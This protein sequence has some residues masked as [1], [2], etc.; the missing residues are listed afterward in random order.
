MIWRPGEKALRHSV[1]GTAR[2]LRESRIRRQCRHGL[3]ITPV[4]IVVTMLMGM[5]SASADRIVLAPRGTIQQ[6]GAVLG[7][8]AVQ[9]SHTQN[10]LGF[11][12]LGIPGNDLG[13]ELEVERDDLWRT[14]RETFSL[15]YLVIPEGLTN[16]IGPAISV[17][18]RDIL[19]RGREGR[20]FFLAGTKSFPLSRNQ[21]RLVRDLKL[22]GG[23]GT[24][25]L[26]GPFVG[27]EARL[28]MGFRI[29]AEYAAR[30]PDFELALPAGKHVTLRAYTL[31][32]SA[33]YGASLGWRL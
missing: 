14:T 13:L 2:I 31:D 28:T 1:D 16:N 5:A 19:N 33:F 3:L 15:Q 9:G 20:A 21:E 7:E 10:T 29:M 17:G 4:W 22:H 26:D 12:D 25:H 32:G 18:A 24:S 8:L 27:A 11:V 6:A 23:Y 30:R